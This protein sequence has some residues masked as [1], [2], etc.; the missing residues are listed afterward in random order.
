MHGW[1]V[2]VAKVRA[3]K[4]VFAR[5]GKKRRSATAEVDSWEGRQWGNRGLLSWG[6]QHSPSDKT[7]GGAGGSTAGAV[8]GSLGSG[9]LRQLEPADS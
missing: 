4:M 2:G 6:L 8:H 5:V 7:L 9:T 1:P 3:E